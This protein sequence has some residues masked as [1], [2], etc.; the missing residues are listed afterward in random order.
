MNKSMFKDGVEIKQR[1]YKLNIHN[2]YTV[3]G[4]YIDMDM[5]HCQL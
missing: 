4:I 5:L 1:I 3:Y 2:V